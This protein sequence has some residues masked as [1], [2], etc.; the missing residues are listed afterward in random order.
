[1]R[2]FFWVTRRYK[3]KKRKQFQFMINEKEKIV[4]K[5]VY[6]FKLKLKYINPEIWRRILVPESYSFWD[7]HVAIQDSMGW[8][9]C[10]LHK[11]KIKKENQVLSIGIP[12]DDLFDRE[13]EL[14][15]GWL[16]AIKKYFQTEGT[17]ISYVY[18]FGDYWEHEITLEKIFPEN[19]DQK[20]PTC[21]GGEN[22]C[23]PE[24]CG[25][26]PGYEEIL[27]VLKN[28]KNDQY[29]D[30]RDWLG[31]YFDPKDFNAEEVVFDDPKIRFRNIKQ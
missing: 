26:P 7:L 3:P 30:T 5:S 21:I 9:E 29:K 1:M 14:L 18:D 19:P 8:E 12:D 11:F 22:A 15:A 13:S 31:E 20:Y 24:D 4:S 16:T 2:D 28:P 27:R 23:P 6:Q 17:S 25:G 10:H